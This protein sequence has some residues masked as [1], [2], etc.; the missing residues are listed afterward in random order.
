MKDTKKIEWFYN[1]CAMDGIR[2]TN[3][4]IIEFLQV[5]DWYLKRNYSDVPRI[6]N[7]QINNDFDLA[8]EYVYENI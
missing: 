8:Y 4:A 3:S 1:R 2:P 6:V 5:L 7:K